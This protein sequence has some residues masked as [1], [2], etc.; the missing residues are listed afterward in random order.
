[1]KL[2]PNAHID[3]TGHLGSLKSSL[4]PACKLFEST[5]PLYHLPHRSSPGEF[6]LRLFILWIITTAAVVA[7][8]AAQ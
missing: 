5:P 4:T 2:K 7:I 1:M 6:I 8:I 3:L